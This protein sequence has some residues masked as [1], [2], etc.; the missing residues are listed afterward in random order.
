MR[1]GSTDAMLRSF[2]AKQKAL[3]GK[4]KG[5]DKKAAE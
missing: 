5:T 4:R 3:K 2:S 1:T